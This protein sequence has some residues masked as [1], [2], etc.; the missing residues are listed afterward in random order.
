MLSFTRR[1][2]GGLLAALG[3][4]PGRLFGARN[5]GNMDAILRAGIERRGI[6]AVAAMIANAN[7]VTYSGAFGTR[8]SASGVPVGIDSI[9]SIASMTKAITSVAAMQMVEQGKV[10]LDEPMARLL[11]K[12]AE[13]RILEGFD[14]AGKPMLRPASTPITLKHLLTHTSGFCYDTW[15]EGMFRYASYTGTLG[16]RMADNP[17]PLQF[18]PGTRW[19]Y[20]YS[21]EWAGR[22]VEALSG[23]T[24]E[25]YFQRNIFAPLGMKDTSFILPPGK[26]DRLVS[27]FQKETDGKFREEPRTPPKPPQ[28]F[29]G[30][31]GLYST[32]GD[33]T[34]FM[35]TILR[36]GLA[37]GRDRLLKAETIETMARNQIGDLSAGKLKSVR[38]ATSADVDF[39]PG[40]KDGFGLGFLINAIAYSGGRSAGTLAWAGLENTYYWI[41]RRRALSAVIMMRFHPF[42]DPLAMGLLSDFEHAVYASV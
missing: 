23:L 19:Q 17:P 26:F 20:G 21:T 16:E 18:E 11:P 6:P 12:L 35:Q 24:L 36:G 8:D 34:R 5:G 37:A 7:G 22:L 31:G 41:D 29:N 15:H 40:F 13:V 39:H 2:F 32:V 14:A 42:G 10:K 28:K 4:R 3:A 38:P 1:Q 30:G 27:E 33:Y 25:Q 9:F